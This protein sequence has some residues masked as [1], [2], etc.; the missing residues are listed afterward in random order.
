MNLLLDDG[1]RPNFTPVTKCFSL[2][3][4]D[5]IFTLFLWVL[6]SSST[7]PV[8]FGCSRIQRHNENDA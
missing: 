5:A 6:T 3:T 8:V 4:A 1:I 7:I 2:T